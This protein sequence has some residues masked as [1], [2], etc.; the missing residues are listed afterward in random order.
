MLPGALLAGRLL[1][2][3]FLTCPLGLLRPEGGLPFG[4]RLPFGTGEGDAEPFVLLEFGVGGQPR[5]G[6]TDFLDGHAEPQGDAVQVVLLL[7][8]VH[9]L[10]ARIQETAVHLLLRCGGLLWLLHL[11]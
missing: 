5:I 10:A 6:G 8:A 11:L 4:L 1:C 7:D 2:S 3:R 9:L